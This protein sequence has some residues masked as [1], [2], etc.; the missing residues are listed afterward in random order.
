MRWGVAIL[1]AASVGAAPAG[2]LAGSLPFWPMPDGLQVTPI[3]DEMRLNGV[4]IRIGLV[5]GTID[6]RRFREEMERSCHR[7][8]GRFQEQGLGLKQLWSCIHE[9][10]S[11][12]A[13]W[14]R[15]GDRIV[16]EISTLRMDAKPRQSAL[17][18][19]LPDGAEL[20]SD[21]ESRDGDLRGRVLMVDSLLSV[22]QLRTALLREAQAR[23]WKLTAPLSDNLGRLSLRKPKESLDIA[24]PAGSS[25]GSRAVIVWQN[26]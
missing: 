21:L 5:S 12:T 2:A 3:A 1:V 25:G 23:G 14:R 10:L 17:P 15:E 7:E 16:G 18:T 24:F 13:Q 4:P 19:P 11:Q 9:P 6:Q 20:V 22:P 26:R 8:H